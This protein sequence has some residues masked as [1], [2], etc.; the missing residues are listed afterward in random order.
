M[1]AVLLACLF[2]LAPPRA[3]GQILPSR[4][5]TALDGR[6]T[7]GGTLSASVAA[8]DD[9]AYYNL[10]RYDTDILRMVQ[11]SLGATLHVSQR[12]DL[13]AAGTGQTA[14][15]HWRW[16]I[17][18]SALFLSARPSARAS[19]AITGGIMQPAFGSFL[20]HS[21][22]ADNL[23]IGYPLAYQYATSVR[24]G[25]F[26]AS[27]DELLKSR[28]LGA[29]PR[30]SLGGYAEP[31]L[32][33]VNPFG[34]SAGVGL[35]AGSSPLHVDLALTRGGIAQRLSREGGGGWEVSTR[36]EARLGPAV[37]FGA[38]FAHGSYLDSGNAAAL[39]E[40]AKYN[41][42]PRETA[43]G[44]HVEYSRDYWLLRGEAIF[45][46]RTVP[47][48]SAPYLAD[49]L[50]SRWVGVEGR[51]KLIPGAYLAGRMERLWFSRV[52]GT[53]GEQTWDSNV[54]RI[55]AGGGY[56]LSRNATAKLTFQHDWRDS[57]WY[58]RQ[59]LI[60]AQ[61]ALWF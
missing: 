53:A 8:S 35:S 21:Y 10:T 27:A 33:L 26:P 46:R 31:G 1:P 47:A 36:A 41:R 2:A 50:W 54:T 51:Y 61:V 59:Q 44:T 55:E 5:I 56:S 40:T 19:L 11:F 30:Y 52:A 38:S 18:P 39:A 58:P 17:Y 43:I 60:S 49:P 9:H 23:L 24:S 57:R 37:V 7:I 32:P 3:F 20:S 15:D 28:G 12:I 34:W 25:A 22:G 16:D 42:E 48:F 45:S 13:V 6:L 4:P 14:I 29:A